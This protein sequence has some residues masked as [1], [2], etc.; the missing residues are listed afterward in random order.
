MFNKICIG[1]AQFGLNYGIT[2][3]C[4]IVSE[5]EVFS[6]LNLARSYG[7]NSLDTASGYGE[8]QKLIGKYLKEKKQFFIISKLF[9][10]FKK[11][12]D[13]FDIDLMELKFYKSLEDL[14][15]ERIS[16]L[17]I[18][19][20]WEL[21]N[22]NCEKLIKWLKNLSNEGKI[23]KIGISI[24]EKKDLI[25]IDPF[26]FE[27]IQLPI[28]L[29]NQKLM[30]DLSLTHLLKNSFLIAR[31]IYLQGLLLIPAKNWPSWI[32]KQ[33]KKHHKDLEEFL[34]SQNLSFIDIALAY[35][36]SI[37]EIDKF[38]VGLCSR[39]ELI[40]LKNSLNNANNFSQKDFSNWELRDKILIDPRKWHNLS[41]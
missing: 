11:N 31:S 26:F 37:P 18:H 28:S 22:R 9:L 30:K 4:G 40:E 12:C 41:K 19:N 39:I 5:K 34:N 15:Q 27:A 7:I 14:N 25:G 29:Y 6:I 21:K 10:E 35:I 20:P 23:E 33:S 1:T 13:E 2:N 36:N 8:S 17:L 16:C 32:N 24:Y 3:K 38:I